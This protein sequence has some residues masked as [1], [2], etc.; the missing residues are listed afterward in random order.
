MSF[1]KF[2]WKI[3]F[4]SLRKTIVVVNLSCIRKRIYALLHGKIH[5]KSLQ[6]IRCAIIGLGRIGS[7]LEFDRFREKPAS[8]AGAIMSHPDCDIV[9]G[10][11]VDSEKRRAFRKAWNC[12][13]LYDDCARMLDECE[14]DILHI[15]T[16]PDTHRAILE[17]ALG[18]T[19]PVIVCEKPL[20]ATLTDAEEMAH[21]AEKSHSRIIINHER[22]YALNYAH[23]K[24]VIASQQYGRLV[25]IA[26]KV[27][28]GYRSKAA[29][30]LL[31]DGTH[32]IDLLR[33]LANEELL[34]HSVMGDAASTREPLCALMKAG[35]VPMLLETGPGRDHIVFEVDLSFERG[36]IVAGNGIYEEYESAES[37]YYEHMKSLR[38]KD[39]SFVKTEYFKR[40][41]DD[42]VALFKDE[43]TAPD[44]T[45]KDGLAAM[46]VIDCIIA[47]AGQK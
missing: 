14:I 8:H 44:S 23:V 5:M 47:M 21:M 43:K 42:A 33:F 18:H 31:D 15:A 1:P 37:P 25:S 36:R 12:N 20:A 17:C 6:R 10:C 35:A 46:R 30:A 34:V 7:A 29:D 9:A 22:R 3:A 27:Y 40:M 26:A 4:F 16:P 2:F 24:K 32:M 39:I 28:M 19:I 11:D 38:R 13:A 45:L 41:F